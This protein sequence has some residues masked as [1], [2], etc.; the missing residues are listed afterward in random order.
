MSRFFPQARLLRDHQARST[1][2][3]NVDERSPQTVDKA[4]AAQ[5][6]VAL[7]TGNPQAEGGCPQRS[8]TS[9][10]GCPLFGNATRPLTV[11]S[12]R[13]HTGLPRG[14]V[15]KARKPGD[16]P[17]ENSP[18]PVHAMCRT[19]CSPQ[20]G[21]VVHCLRPQGRWTKYRC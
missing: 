19:F 20:R 2:C 11:P 4:R 10:H 14:A 6:R 1:G 8:P 7:S 3:G 15:G 9:P 21:P 5:P 16:G 17:G 13:R 12:E 18:L